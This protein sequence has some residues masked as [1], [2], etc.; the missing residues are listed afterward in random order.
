MASPQGDHLLAGLVNMWVEKIRKAEERKKK[1][2]QD[3]AD[4]ALK[5]YVPP[6]GNYNWMYE[7]D[8]NGKSGVGIDVEAPSMRMTLN[9]V[10]E[11]VQIYGPLLYA[12]NP[13]RQVNPRT[14]VDLPP[15]A[16]PDPVLLQALQQQE[17]LRAQNDQL[18]SDLLSG[19]LNWTPTELRLKEHSDRGVRE[20]LIKGRGCL[21]STV[22]VPAG[23]ERKVVGSTFDSVDFLQIDPDAET[24]ED[25]WWIARKR[26]HPV[27]QVEKLFNLK[28]GSLKDKAT[29][30]SWGKQAET[31]SQ[32]KGYDRARGLTNDLMVYWEVYSRMGCGGRMSG[33]PAELANSDGQPGDMAGFTRTID[34]IVGDFVFLVVAPGVEY[35]L[36][37]P[38][39]VQA[40]PM[41]G[42]GSPQD[43][44]TAVKE[45]LAWPVPYYLDSKSPWPVSV[46][47]FLPVPRSA[48]P[49]P[50]VKPAM[51]ELRFLCWAYSFVACKI[52]NTLR[53]VV[54]I[55]KEMSEQFKIQ[56]LEGA[57]LSM[58]ELDTN[59]RDIKECVQV[60]QFPQ[61]NA[62]IW[63]IIEAVEKN[64]DKRVGLNE[65]FYGQS[66]TQDRSAAESQ[67]KTQHMNIRPDDMAERVETWMTEVSRKEAVAARMLLSPKDVLPVLGLTASALW[68]THVSSADPAI[69]RELEYRIE[70]GS[71]RK[72]NRDRDQAN[73]DSSMQILLPIF[74]KFAQG[75]GQLGPINALIAFW[76]KTR[77]I[78]PGPFMLPSPPPPPPPGAGPPPGAAPP[79][80]GPPHAGGPPR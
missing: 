68:A 23:S 69:F 35:P 76:A 12:K 70:A 74:D 39:E 29:Y 17:V 27:W 52:K 31:D 22:V 40:L 20:A 43:G 25:A 66:Q 6:D 67:I 57:D 79:P 61:M 72:P 54:A 3:S 62:D 37:L 47:D 15:S 71:T 45:K 1:E 33:S 11:M 2:F 5:F 18:K 14:P 64:F 19:Y 24:F 44:L 80:P 53:D 30:E 58:V 42:D 34:P 13:V 10:S 9:K 41:T 21:W 16:I 32:N 59:N 7:G 77:D 36:N 46:L 8:V 48:W 65:V 38:P 51:G 60:L 26:C 75:T 4:E 73:A 50:L 55:L 78:P 49:M 56:V 28:K 63:K